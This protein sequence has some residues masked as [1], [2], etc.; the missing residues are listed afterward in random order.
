VPV[1][2][3]PSAETLRLMRETAA[4][5]LAEVY[6]QFTRR[7]LGLKAKAPPLRVEYISRYGTCPLVMHAG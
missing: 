4:P 1:T 6:A 7:V 2:P 3:A 5:M